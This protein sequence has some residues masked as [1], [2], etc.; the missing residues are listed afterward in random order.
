MSSKNYFKGYICALICNVSLVG[1]Q[2]GMKIL[3]QYISAYLVLTIRASFQFFFCFYLL[4]KFK[5][6]FH[7]KNKTGIC[8]YI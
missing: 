8:T 3:G 7:I 2:I 4:S 5:M 1:S 6:N